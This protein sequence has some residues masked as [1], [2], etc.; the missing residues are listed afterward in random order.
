MPAPTDA[1]P[2]LGS[3]AAVVIRDFAFP[4][5]DPRFHGRRQDAS[6]DGALPT[7]SSKHRGRLSNQA[8]AAPQSQAA[9]PASASQSSSDSRAAEHGVVSKA[10]A[11]ASGT[12]NAAGAA[13]GVS[14]GGGATAEDGGDDD[15]DEDDED[16]KDDSGIKVQWEWTWSF[17]APRSSTVSKSALAALK[18]KD[19][20]AAVLPLLVKHLEQHVNAAATAASSDAKVLKAYRVRAVFPFIKATEYEMSI[21]SGD[22]LV[23]FALKDK[24]EPAH[25]DDGGKTSVPLKTEADGGK[26]QQM[27]RWMSIDDELADD[28]PVRTSAA[29][30]SASDSKTIDA[31]MFEPPVE[32]FAK[33]VKQFL[34]YN[35]SYGASWLTALKVKVKGKWTSSASA[36]PATAV[37]AIGDD[38]LA[39]ISLRDLGL[40]P[41]NYVE[42]Q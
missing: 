39:K 1:V 31:L 26:G 19:L 23:V 5:T 27:G 33:E 24:Q 17:K 21:D 29:K 34:G 14:Q 6:A 12:S 4:T 37:G 18:A 41:G 36:A 8:S 35:Q 42:P 25:V 9:V 2:S 32:D 22:E 15:D 7:T 28:S 38:G 3:W 16:D 20:D 10:G 30:A 13:T 40:V 11:S